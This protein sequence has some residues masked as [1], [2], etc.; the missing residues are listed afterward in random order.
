VLD[1]QHAA[2][3]FR[4]VVSRRG[5]QP[6]HLLHAIARVPLARSLAA[7]GAVAEARQTYADFAAAWRNA[8]AHQPLLLAAATEA[9]ALPPLSDPAR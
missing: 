2:V 4:E 3:Q 9:A 1:H 8:D 6:T 5:N 7:A